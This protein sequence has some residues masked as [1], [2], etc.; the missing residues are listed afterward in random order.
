MNNTLSR[1]ITW[2]P[3]NP[4]F[5]FFI[6]STNLLK[7]LLFTACYATVLNYIL[8]P[9]TVVAEAISTFNLKINTKLV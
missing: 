5:S 7:H 2:S 6:S 8:V 9:T 3:N 1:T 4:V